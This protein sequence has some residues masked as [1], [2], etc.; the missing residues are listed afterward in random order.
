MVEQGEVS[1]FEFKWLTLRD[2]KKYAKK[3]DDYREMKDYIDIMIDASGK[4]TYAAN[5]G[6]GI[7]I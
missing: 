6:K 7:L 3:M 5:K 2:L 1:G 4:T